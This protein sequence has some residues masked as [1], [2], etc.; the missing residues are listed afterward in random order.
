MVKIERIDK[1]GSFETMFR[2]SDGNT[3]EEIY[4]WAWEADNVE[5]VLRTTSRER[6]QII[7]N[8]DG[9]KVVKS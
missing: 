2:I 3:A 9:R 6:I 4:V 7:L 5:S 1:A 8:K